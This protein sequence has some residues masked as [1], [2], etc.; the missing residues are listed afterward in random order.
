MNNILIK[1]PNIN[2]IF[3]YDYQLLNINDF[4]LY[5]KNFILHL[6]KNYTDT[7]PNIKFTTDLKQT[8]KVYKEKIDLIIYFNTEKKNNDAIIINKYKYILINL[9]NYK[10]NIDLL[11]KPIINYYPN[12]YINYYVNE[13]AEKKE[14]NV[15]TFNNIELKIKNIS[16]NIFSNLI[17]NKIFM[18]PF[19]ND[20]S[21]LNNFNNIIKKIRY[22]NLNQIY[23]NY[24]ELYKNNTEK[25]DSDFKYTRKFILSFDN[26][27]INI[28]TLVEYNKKIDYIEQLKYENNN[29]ILFHNYNDIVKYNIV[30]IENEINKLSK[31][32]NE[33]D[34][35]FYTENIKNEIIKKKEEIEKL[36]KK[37][38][39]TI[40]DINS[41][42]IKF[43][44]NYD[45]NNFW[46]FKNYKLRQNIFKNYR[47]VILKDNFNSNISLLDKIIEVYLSGAIPLI[48]K[49]NDFINKNI[50]NNILIPSNINDNFFEKLFITYSFEYLIGTSYIN[51]KSIIDIINNE[52]N[53]EHFF[54][55]DNLIKQ[56]PEY[57]NIKYF[58]KLG[59]LIKDSLS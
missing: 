25:L 16:N 41:E 24:I 9:N 22:N 8:I 30:M 4:A 33:N 48:N 55:N 44:S 59:N 51:N 15:I 12:T 7:V 23:N 5:F 35:T 1:I 10:S 11:Q 3:C 52:N 21:K 26:S 18:N 37:F 32:I 6:I 36:E 34:N 47:F 53:I 13:I 29:Y 31:E 28:D 14:N 57:L 46:N 49:E 27:K 39:L 2:D 42:N 20:I 38:L 17:L 40:E 50:L 58:D 56:I 45:D 43:D 19:D 54:N